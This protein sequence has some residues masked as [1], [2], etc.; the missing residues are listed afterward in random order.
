MTC[1]SVQRVK[2]ARTAPGARIAVVENG[3]DTSAFAGAGAAAGVSE[4]AVLVTTA[5]GG[6]AG[7]G[8]AWA[9]TTGG[10]TGVARGAAGGKP[11]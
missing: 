1:A 7:G 9:T 2:Y 4:L 6:G 11:V 10:A 3:V 8:A 5:G